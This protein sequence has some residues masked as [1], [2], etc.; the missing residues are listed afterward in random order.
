MTQVFSKSRRYPITA[1]LMNIIAM[2]HATEIRN[3]T[4]RLF[5]RV[6]TA[7]DHERIAKA[8]DKRNRKAQKRLYDQA[9]CKMANY[10]DH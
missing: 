4:R 10:H 3:R 5:P 7:A 1:A 8:A 2:G 6:K 9:S